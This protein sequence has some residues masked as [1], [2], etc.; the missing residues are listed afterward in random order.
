MLGNLFDLPLYFYSRTKAGE[1]DNMKTHPGFFV[2]ERES[3]KGS[4]REG[5]FGL[6]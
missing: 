3:S 2:P 4:V 5:I 6:E 1:I